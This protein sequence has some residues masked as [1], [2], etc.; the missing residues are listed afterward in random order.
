MQ[1]VESVI[2]ISGIYQEA[3]QWVDGQEWKKPIH[4]KKDNNT[5]LHSAAR[6]K[7]ACNHDA[8]AGVTYIMDKLPQIESNRDVLLIVSTKEASIDLIVKDF[9]LWLEEPVPRD[10]QLA[11][12]MAPMEH[13]TLGQ[14]K[15][16]FEVYNSMKATVENVRKVVNNV[17]L[18]GGAKAGELDHPHRSLGTA[19]Y[20]EQ[21]RIGFHGT[22]TW[23]ACQEVLSKRL[24]SYSRETKEGI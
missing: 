4:R 1:D 2:R 24:A 14:E 19:L 18:L 20:D 12:R 21:G 6:R 15:K 13:Q 7:F 10:V 5:C 9:A 8:V 3:L 17:R 22:K 11:I 16:W 23:Y